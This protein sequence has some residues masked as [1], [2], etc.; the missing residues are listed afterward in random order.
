MRPLWLQ[1]L[2]VVAPVSG[3]GVVRLQSRYNHSRLI[4]VIARQRA[5][6]ATSDSA[7]IPFAQHRL[8]S[9]R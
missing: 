7:Q 2:G 8:E 6:Q 5:A 9:A 1:T 4:A 3:L